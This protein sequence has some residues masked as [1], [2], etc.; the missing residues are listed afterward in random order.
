MLI[1]DELSIFI[2]LKIRPGRRILK[3][4]HPTRRM[5]RLEFKLGRINS[6]DFALKSLELERARW[7]LGTKTWRT[8]RTPY[9]ILWNSPIG[10]F[11]IT[12]SLFLKASLGAHPFIW[13]WDFIHME[14]NLICMWMKY[15]FHMK[16]WAPRLALAKRLKVIRKWP[17]SKNFNAR[18]WCRI[19][20]GIKARLRGINSQKFTYE[21]FTSRIFLWIFFV[22]FVLNLR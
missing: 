9:W 14:M 7:V 3:T 2:R 6:S 8:P 18:D 22:L 4:D 5:I 10:H 16:G 17:I 19:Y 12:F 21:K 20:P 13:K 15:H 1:L 11:R